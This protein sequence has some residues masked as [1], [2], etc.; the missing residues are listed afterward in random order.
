ME[1]I[2]FDNNVAM[3]KQLQSQLDKVEIREL[4]LLKFAD[5]VNATN[6]ILIRKLLDA[7]ISDKIYTTEQAP[8]LLRQRSARVFKL[9]NTFFSADENKMFIGENL[10]KAAAKE[11][12]INRK[13]ELLK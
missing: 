1:I 8:S 13:E 4:S 6:N 7:T 3:F 11:K 5:I 2:F 10:L 12:N 9:C